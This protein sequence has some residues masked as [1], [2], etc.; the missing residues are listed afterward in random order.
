MR[1]VDINIWLKAADERAVEPIGAVGT[2]AFLERDT[3]G[4]LVKGEPFKLPGR[5]KNPKP[6]G[7]SAGEVWSTGGDGDNG[8][9]DKFVHSVAVHGSSLWHCDRLLVGSTL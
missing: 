9:S 8:R 1:L 3:H 4:G 2:Y 7:V 5:P 6:N